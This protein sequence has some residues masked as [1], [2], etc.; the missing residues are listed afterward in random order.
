MAKTL[1]NNLLVNI[2]LNYF[3]SWAY[4]IDPKAQLLGHGQ[5]LPNMNRS[6]S[7]ASSMTIQDIWMLAQQWTLSPAACYYV[8]CEIVGGKQ[9]AGVHNSPPGFCVLQMLPPRRIV[10]AFAEHSSHEGIPHQCTNGG[11]HSN[12]I[13]PWTG[14][15][16]SRA[17]SQSDMDHGPNHWYL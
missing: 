3:K 16:P 1:I 15:L 10:A 9:A 12:T 14:L 17:H 4:D 6:A 7:G 2:L 11:Q 8:I 13:K 5:N